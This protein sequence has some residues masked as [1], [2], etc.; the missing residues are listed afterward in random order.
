M[1]GFPVREAESELTCL[2]RLVGVVEESQVDAE[3]DMVRAEIDMVRDSHRVG[4]D[5]LLVPGDAGTGALRWRRRPVDD[6]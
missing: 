2:R 1:A 6:A 3:I 5:G 4:A